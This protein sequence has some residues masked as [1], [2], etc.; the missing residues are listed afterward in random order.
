MLPH[1]DFNQHHRQSPRVHRHFQLAV[2]NSAE[3]AGLLYHGG[4]A[5][6]F[7]SLRSF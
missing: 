7:Y 2:F 3:M 6:T 1:F 5:L 4:A